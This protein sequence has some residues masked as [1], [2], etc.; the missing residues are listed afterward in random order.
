MWSL[1]VLS[2]SEAIYTDETKT[3]LENLI[4]SL[5]F[6]GTPA[7]VD[8]RK[9]EVTREKKKRHEWNEKKSTRET[10]AVGKEGEKTIKLKSIRARYIS[11][12]EKYKRFK[13]PAKIDLND[14]S[15]TLNGSLVEL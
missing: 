7:A 4:P 12:K 2:P 9:R 10:A 1:C 3:F 8:C 14:V 11:H 5:S 6:C 13:M 15:Q